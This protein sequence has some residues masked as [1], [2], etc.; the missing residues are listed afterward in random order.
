MALAAPPS[1]PRSRRSLKA[2]F[3]QVIGN[4]TSQLA[5]AYTTFGLPPGQGRV[6]SSRRDSH[7]LPNVV[8]SGVTMLHR[9]QCFLFV[10]ARRNDLMGLL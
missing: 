2:G 10:S 8:Q 9:T 1:L 7:P 6:S 3:D 5:G 4:L